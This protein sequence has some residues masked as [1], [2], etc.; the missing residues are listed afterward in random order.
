MVQMEKLMKLAALNAGIAVSNIVLFSEELM[1]VVLIGGSAFET[2]FGITAIF[3][4]GAVFA[5]GNYSILSGKGKKSQANDLKTAEDCIN[6]LKRSGVK[7]TFSKEMATITEQTRRFSKKKDT[8]RDLL[9]QKFSSEEMSYSKFQGVINEV[10]SVFSV[11]IKNIVKKLSAFDVEDYRRMRTRR[12]KREFSKEFIRTKMGIYHEYIRFLKESIKDNEQILLKM[13]RLLLE[14]SRLN[15]LE[16]G[17]MEKM[18]AMKEI[19][20][21]INKTKLYK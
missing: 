4:S 18:D 1:G 14:L 6:A 16:N 20:E 3:M 15:S 7:R 10:E 21:L 9:L 8:A 17:E 13:D 12:A 11:N 5:V 2:V 19:D